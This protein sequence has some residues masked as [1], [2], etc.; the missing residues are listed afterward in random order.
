MRALAICVLLLVQWNFAF[1]ESVQAF[2]SPRDHLAER[3]IQL[4]D[5]ENKSLQIGIYCFTHSGIA[6]ALI[7]AKNRGVAVEIVVDPFSVKTRTPL[8]RLAKAEIPIYVWTAPII[9]DE[10]GKFQK[11]PIMHDKFCIFG[12]KRVWTGSFN[13]TYQADHFN[14]ENAILLDDPKIVAAFQEQ[15][16]MLKAKSSLPYEEFIAMKS[17]SCGKKK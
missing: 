13:F 3:L 4:I 12:G 11:S 9:E 16:R 5:Q 6:K 7:A 1:S 14:A 15:F 17:L 2:F 10:K 8:A